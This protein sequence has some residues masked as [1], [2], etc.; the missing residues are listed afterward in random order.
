MSMKML[1]NM[2]QMQY[3]PIKAML[4]LSWKFG[5]SK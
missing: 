1:T 4:K 2:T 3:R 5:E